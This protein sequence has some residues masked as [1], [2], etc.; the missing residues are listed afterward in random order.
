M[1][2]GFSLRRMAAADLDA[3]AALEQAIYPLPWTRGSFDFELH[4][5]P[6][7]LLWVAAAPGG[8]VAAYCVAW[9]LDEELHI[10]NFAVAAA[11]RRQ[12]LGR[13]LLGHLL[14]E[15]AELGMGSATLEVRTGN[16]AARQLYRRLGF[17]DVGM[18]PRFYSDGED[19][20]IMQLAALPR[21]E[22][23]ESRPPGHSQ[24]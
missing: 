11:F 19:A 12:G 8:E 3:V 10:A 6:A 23:V 9:R 7:A 2:T 13:R 14:A 21:V 17:A 18:R 1:N 24:P 20:V 5:N 4:E 15:A 16:Q 22:M